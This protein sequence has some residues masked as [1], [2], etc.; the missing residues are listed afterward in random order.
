MLKNL[1][2]SAKTTL[3][4]GTII[5]FGIGVVGV[6][7]MSIGRIEGTLNQ[8]TDVAAPTVE[9]AADV[10]YFVNQ[11]LK[12]GIEILADEDLSDL[13]AR[14]EQFQE[15]VSAYD[16]AIAELDEIVSDPTLQTTL[17]ESTPEWADFYTKANAMFAAH[18]TELEEE[19]KADE[20]L[21]IFESDG[22]V[23]IDRLTAIANAQEAEMQAAENRAD[24]LA[25]LSTTTAQE[26]NDLIGELFEVDY[27]AYEA[28]VRL[29]LIVAILEGAAREY[30]AAELLGQL[31]SIRA[32]F[33]DAYALAGPELDVLELR[34]ETDAERQE[35]ADIKSDLQTWVS[36][37][38]ADEQ[39]FDT[40]RDM[41]EAEAEADRLAEEMNVAAAVLIDT[42]DAVASA[43]DAV[44]DGA[45]ET[46]AGQVRTAQLTMM[47][48][49][50]GMI[51]GG[52]VIG[53]AS[54]RLISRPIQRLTETMEVVSSGDLSPELERSEETHEIG[55]MTN[56]MVVF[57]EN[58]RK[59]KEL[60]ESLKIKEQEEAARKEE[61]SKLEAERAEAQ[62]REK[63]EAERAVAE[64][65]A[66]MMRVLRESIGSVVGKAKAGNFSSR[67][68]VK[69]DDETLDALASNVNE[70]LDSVDNGLSAAGKA[71]SRISQ[72]DLTKPMEGTFEGAFHDLQTN[73]NDMLAS[74]KELVAGI[75]GSTENVSGSSIELSDTAEALSKQT[76][77]NAASLEET[78]A[79]LDEMSASIRQVNENIT[80]ANSN[81][82]LASDAAK[83]GSAVAVE[84]ADAMN[85]INDASSEIAKVVGVINDI[86]F[87]INLLAL[88]AGVEAARAGEAGRG[89]SVV[90]SE[91]RQLAQRASEASSE[92]A[93]VISRSDAAVSD[94]VEKVK[95]AEVSLH[96]ISESIAD[97]SGSIEDVA[98]AISEQVNGISEINSAVALVDQNTQ[99]QAASFEEVTAAS[100]VLSNEAEGLKKSTDRFKTGKETKFVSKTP[101][102]KPAQKTRTAAPAPV[103]DGNLAHDLDGWD[104]F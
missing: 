75:S 57:L 38:E 66:E 77:Q 30:M 42:L 46:A 33:S 54:R 18:V 65:R 27:P 56:A 23:L 3:G 32:E 24:E 39:L 58:S 22:T 2:I 17:E 102:V 103:V 44:S 92:I 85:K 67:V 74:L 104:E 45:D 5:A 79:A 88:N 76:E 26:L 8:I 13:A 71:L 15:A 82:R 95:G 94:G 25:A 89:F 62:A 40:H 21:S 50:A 63:E 51:A 90:A 16:A 14:K 68:D 96:K 93:T 73:T 37:S 9:T 36:N 91:V 47:A 100:R 6:S 12:V 11:A 4:I 69:F 48:L 84:A 20:L 49:L 7:V 59:A 99:Q 81:A 61:E 101:K 80:S 10:T 19:M 34:A 72:G 31:P 55:K 86:A 78:S 53:F 70:L 28:A 60:D 41:L 43:A 64:E 83:N 87:Q 1:S 97:V 29:T 98:K 35:I 52:L